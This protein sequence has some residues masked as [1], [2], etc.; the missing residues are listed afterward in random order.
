MRHRECLVV[1]R[2]RCSGLAVPYH[3][4]RAAM[5]SGRAGPSVLPPSV[6]PAPV[7]STT[8]VGKLIL[9][10]HAIAV[11]VETFEVLAYFRRELGLG[12]RSVIPILIIIM[13]VSGVLFTALTVCRELAA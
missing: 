5:S 13:P 4:A 7:M 2:P 10:Q 3:D 6:A 11:A 9:V 8:R 1:R 12:R